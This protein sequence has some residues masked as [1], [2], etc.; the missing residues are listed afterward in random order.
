[1]NNLKH[2]LDFGWPY[3]RRYWRRL[4]I[5]I[6]C[7]M[8]F[9]LANGSF[10][11]AVRTLTDRLT[12]RVELTGQGNPVGGKVHKSK[13]VPS[14]FQ[15][16]LKQI[17]AKVNAAIDPWL[18]LAGGTLGWQRVLGG[19]LFLPLLVSVR[20]I[21]D[22]LSGY[23]MGWVSERVIN[24]LRGDVLEKL[25][26]LSLDY[27]NRSTTGDMLT[28][29]N[30]DTMNLHRALRVGC[31]DLVKEPFSIVGVFTGML[32][33]DWKLTLLTLVFL[34]LCLFPLIVLGKKTRRASRLGRKANVSQNSMLVELLTGIR[35]IKAFSLEAEQLRRFREYSK[36]LIH[37]GMKSVQAKELV[38]PLIEVISML[39]LGMLVVYVFWAARTVPDLV[40]FLTGLMMFFLPIKKLAGIHILFEQASAG[41]ERL[42]EI[43][44]EQPTVKEPVIAKPLSP[45]KSQITFE[46]VS[47]SYRQEPVLRDI[48]LAIPRGFRLG[49]AG[50]SGSGKSTLTNLIFR[51]Y[52]PTSGAVKIDGLNLREVSLLDL[53]RQMALVSQEIVLFNM[54]VA[55]NIACGKPDATRAEIE[56]AARA[57][58][59]H[60][61][62]V[63]KEQGYDTPI[64]ERGVELSAG[65]RQRIA[66]ARAFVRNAPILVL[67]EATASLDS[68]SEAEVQAA[69]DR[70]AENR[71]VVCVAH[72]L[73]TLAAMDQIIVLSRGRIIEQGSFSELLKA[74][75]EFAE[76][77]NRQG[78]FTQ[79]A[80]QL[81]KKS[82]VN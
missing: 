26:T 55:E 25:S 28:R 58:Y 74:G 64:G 31:A 47:F 53:R 7:G 62:I 72:R 54:T 13:H 21:A 57:A 18:P 27:F 16:Q 15:E 82:G 56:A 35:V 52:D 73:S 23:C 8:V 20:S 80:G 11:W 36:Q 60:D 10:I 75:G 19:L 77:A 2:V 3:L 78:I 30:V 66:I 79:P 69:I 29:I 61:F 49:I 33:V 32:F 38:N 46:N 67:D 50:E 39:G 45:F 65:Q 17:N 40:A 4:T 51:F 12:P 63:E 1:M 68:Q 76:M 59:A 42:I 5:G 6:L 34:P 81:E 41:V 9:G 44:N 48:A 70:L 43:R 37:H 14:A 71:T 22:Y 24:D